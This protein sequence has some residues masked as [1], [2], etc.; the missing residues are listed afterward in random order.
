MD[1]LSAQMKIVWPC[2][3]LL[4]L[5]LNILLEDKLMWIFN[6]ILEEIN[7]YVFTKFNF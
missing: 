4:I 1:S 2:L 7:M 6:K 3:I 5:P